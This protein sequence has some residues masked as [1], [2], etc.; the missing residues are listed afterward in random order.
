M[1]IS[2]RDIKLLLYTGG[3]MT[4]LLVYFCVFNPIKDANEQVKSEIDTLQQELQSRE[5]HAKGMEEYSAQIDEMQGQVDE[6]LSAF[7]AEVKEEDMILYGNQLEQ[8]TEMKIANIGIGTS[9]QLYTLGTDKYLMDTQV[10]YTFTASYD[11]LKKIIKTIQTEEEK[12]NV[13]NVILS[14][15]GNSGKIVG[16]MSVNFYA[17]TGESRTYQKPETQNMPHGTANIFG[18][19]VETTEEDE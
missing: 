13:E 15:D 2:K 19:V 11:D 5:S 14:F 12:H 8:Q 4:L 7:P 10:S 9:N 1:K 18:T 17:V 16:S 6:T 3:L